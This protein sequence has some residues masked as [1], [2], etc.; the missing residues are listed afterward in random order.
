MK[1]LEEFN[2][3]KQVLIAREDQLAEKIDSILK[4]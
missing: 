3:Q 4:A 1:T 2:Q